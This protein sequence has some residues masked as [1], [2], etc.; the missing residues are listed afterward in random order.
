M[1]G[2]VV[3]IPYYSNQVGLAFLLA[4]LQSQMSEDD[5]LY[6]VDDSPDK[7]GVTIAQMYASSRCVVICDVTGGGKGIYHGWNYILQAMLDNKKDG[8]LILNDDV[9][10]AQTTIPNIKRAHGMTDDLALV[11]KSPTREWNSKR[12]DPNFK[13][14]NKITSKD[15]IKP[16]KWMTGFCFYLKREAV[17]KVGLFNT[18][19][20]VWYGDTEY[21]KRLGDKI[22]ML[23]N[24]YIYHFGGSSYQ[25]K[26][27]EVQARI[28][29]DRKLY[30]K[31]RQDH[32][33]TP[34]SSESVS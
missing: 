23:T 5:I 15:D 4:N 20:D 31:I 18:D 7:S 13:W 26:T 33:K 29:V 34:D 27:K 3:G 19:F 9:V 2:I 14:F 28:D 21:E 22:G 12:F 8:A 1:S 16:V 17:E 6:I 24:E 32:P 25:Y 30:D 10:L 11:T